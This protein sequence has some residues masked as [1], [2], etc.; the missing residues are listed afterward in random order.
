VILSS[1][2]RIDPIG[3]LADGVTPVTQPTSA[4]R[5]TDICKYEGCNVSSVRVRF[6]LLF[7]HTFDLAHLLEEFL[8]EGLEAQS[9][10][11]FPCT[12]VYWSG[13]ENSKYA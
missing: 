1:S 10:T 13:A 3:L 7:G 5:M 9:P 2:W 8:S 11:T 6:E 4:P 12:T